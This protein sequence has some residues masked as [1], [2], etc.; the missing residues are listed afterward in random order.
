MA[1]IPQ[2]MDARFQWLPLEVALALVDKNNPTVELNKVY[3]SLSPA[4]QK[5]M[6]A[7]ARAAKNE[8]SK[9]FLAALAQK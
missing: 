5:E 4:K 8:I 3:N 1:R 6:I 7:G 9:S 2:K